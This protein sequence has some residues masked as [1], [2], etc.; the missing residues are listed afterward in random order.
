[1]EKKINDS[2]ISCSYTTGKD[3]S[4]GGQIYATQHWIVEHAFGMSLPG[5]LIL[6]TKRHIEEADELHPAEARE[7]GMVL[8]KVTSAIR[9]VTGA[10][11]VYIL[12][13]G[14]GVRHLHFWVFPRTAA[15]RRQIGIGPKAVALISKQYKVGDMTAQNIKAIGRTAKAIQIFLNKKKTRTTT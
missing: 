12:K 3:Q 7:M 4:V 10:Q 9:F 5:F 6:K 14:E 8:Q 1:M 2:C 15:V 13:F 11:K